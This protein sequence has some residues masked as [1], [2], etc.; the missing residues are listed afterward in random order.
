MM[1]TISTREYRYLLPMTLV[2]P[3]ILLQYQPQ[4]FGILSGIFGQKP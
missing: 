2:L 3:R 4:V 1:L